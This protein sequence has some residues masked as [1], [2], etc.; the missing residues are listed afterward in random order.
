MLA[1]RM[2]RFGFWGWGRLF[3][4][5]GLGPR[6]NFE[7]EYGDPT[8]MGLAV[9]EFRLGVAWYQTSLLGSRYWANLVS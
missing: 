8:T 1:F 5:E 9:V 6:N 4:G 3:S 7:T 2:L